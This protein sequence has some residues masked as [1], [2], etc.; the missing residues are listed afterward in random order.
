M[1]DG[2]V[3]FEIRFEFSFNP[4]EY[5]D[6]CLGDAYDPAEVAVHLETLLQ[7]VVEDVWRLQSGEVDVQRGRLVS[8]T[9]EVEMN[10]EWEADNDF[11]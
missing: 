5:N 1:T 3:K 6:L 7:A 4:D 10:V 11:R 2:R 8:I 9:E